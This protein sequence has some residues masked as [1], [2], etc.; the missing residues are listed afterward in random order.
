ME[1]KMMKQEQLDRVN[2]DEIANGL[3]YAGEMHFKRGEF[4]QALDLFLRCIRAPKS[5][6]SK[7]SELRS[8]Y[9]LGLIYGYLGQEILAKEHLLKALHM[10]T[11]CDDRKIMIN[12]NIHLGM[13][14]AKLED[15]NN[16]LIYEDAAI[17]CLEDCPREWERLRVLSIA[18]SGIVYAKQERIELSEKCLLQIEEIFKNQRIDMGMMPVLNLALRVSYAKENWQRFETYMRQLLDQAILEE[19]FFEALEFYF[20]ICTFLLNKGRKQELRALLDY[21]K[22]YMDMLPLVYLKYYILNFEVLYASTFEDED[23]HWLATQNLLAILPEYEKEQQK[24]KINS[25]DYIEYLHEERD[26]SAKMEQKSKLDPM[27]GL[28]NKFTIEFL[29]DEYF[30]TKDKES[31][32]ALLLLDMDHFKQI[33][34]TLGHLAGDA[35]LADTAAVISRFFKEDALCGRVG[36]DEFMIF[37]KDVKDISS[38]LL[39]AEFL[40]QEIAKTTSERN[41]TIAI[42]ASVGIA[43]STA[44]YY[45]YSS[46]FAAADE[47]LYQ[48]KKEGRNKICVI[49]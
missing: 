19:G 12:C 30:C 23:M 15:F 48:A 29:V 1:T 3:F 17:E 27:T 35:V 8:Y 11:E 26:L 20:D 49:E 5:N 33:N 10:S 42:Q 4:Q 2:L 44:G 39:Q 43:V 21:I 18:Q 24:A 16:A 25:F 37:V 6:V 38:L 28:Y 45:S 47:A 34:D 41:I 22:G 40:R 14:H 46:I 36:G 7:L 9:V 13:L 31:V 32:A